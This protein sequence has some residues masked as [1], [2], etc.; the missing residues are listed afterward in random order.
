MLPIIIDS[1]LFDSRQALHGVFL[2]FI[3]QRSL[4][5]AGTIAPT[6]HSVIA[7]RN[8]DGIK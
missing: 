5:V 3:S 1:R 8:E 7:Q 4:Q 2:I 6:D